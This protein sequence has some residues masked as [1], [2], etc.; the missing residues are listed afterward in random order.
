[1]IHNLIY[2]SFCG[3]QKLGRN[4]AGEFIHNFTTRSHAVDRSPTRIFSQKCPQRSTEV[5]VLR[6]HRCPNSYTQV[7]HWS[8]LRHSQASQVLA[9]TSSARR[10]PSH[11]DN[12][13]SGIVP[14]REGFHCSA[15]WE[16]LVYKC[17]PIDGIHLV[18]NEPF[19]VVICTKAFKNNSSESGLAK[20]PDIAYRYVSM[21]ES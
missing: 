14:K 1:M 16:S 21:P 13:A 12:N 11:R 17:I 7:N 10:R 20:I 6:P 18:V 19:G 5:R 8:R 9:A 4:K 15:W 3:K 2:W